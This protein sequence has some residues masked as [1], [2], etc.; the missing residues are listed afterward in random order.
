MKR[1]L[2]IITTLAVIGF[3]VF[4]FRQ[5]IQARF[6]QTV[7][8]IESY[9]YPCSQPITYKL[10]SFDTHFG[11]SKEYFLKALSDAETIW[12]KP[13]GKNFFTYT[14]NGQLTINLVYDYR[15][16]ATVKLEGLGV[17]VKDNQSSYD[18]LRSKY[19]ALKTEY[20]QTKSNYDS[21]AQTFNDNSKTYQ[22]QVAYWNARGGAPRN[23]YE[24]LQAEGQTLQSQK[25]QLQT[26]QGQL[27]EMVDEI[28]ALVVTLNR[29]V[30]L[31][32]LTVDKYN[33]IGQSRGESFE[34]GLY[35]NDATGQEIDIYEF[36][37]RDKLVRVLAHE[38]GHAL[39][40]PHVADPKAIMYEFNS[41]INEVPT[42]AD[43]SALKIHCG[44]K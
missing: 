18:L 17:V 27:N 22:Q 2:K 42:V 3:I 12:E 21:Q 29:L 37:N 30:D 4:L 19:T 26:M 23:E 32:N 10:G 38:L 8:I 13:L 33:T 35:K 34:E 14:P 39:G 41:S 36:S 9:F 24:Q 5:P 6:D 20:A 15:Q 40:L 1:F 28:N 11:I 16:Q 25:S 7:S 44:I 43:I 31:L